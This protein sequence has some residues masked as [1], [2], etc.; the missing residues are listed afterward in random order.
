MNSA[1]SEKIAEIPHSHCCAKYPP[2]RKSEKGFGSVRENI[3]ITSLR[4]LF[5]FIF[6]VQRL[7]NM[8]FRSYNVKILL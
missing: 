6:S 3:K 8:S 5:F 2:L 1:F 7:Q 4:K